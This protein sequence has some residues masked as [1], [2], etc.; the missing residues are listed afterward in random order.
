MKNKV[1]VIIPSFNE[2]KYIELC[3]RSVLQSEY[4]LLEIIVVDNGSSDRTVDIAR[5]FDI[6]LLI[7]PGVKVGAVRNAGVAEARGDIVI[8]LDADCLVSKNWISEGVAKLESGLDG[9]GGLYDLREN[10][11]WVEKAWVLENGSS[12]SQSAFVGGCIF[13]KKRVFEDVGGFN[14]RLSAG[15]DCDL[16]NRLRDKGY[17]IEIDSSLNVVHLGYPNTLSDFIKRQAWHSED[18]YQLFPGNV[19]DKVFLITHGFLFFL[20]GL[21]ISVFV[22]ELEAV[23]FF[24]V[25]VLVIPLVLSVKRILRFKPNKLSFLYFIEIYAIDFMYLIGRVIGAFRSIRK[26]FTQN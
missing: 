24:L 20:F 1:S 6:E 4:P 10:P 25:G 11:S 22:A 14:E 2:E 18:C 12:L 16:S 19:L 17:G 23:I 5:Q 3:I 15:E 8:F 21:C 9:V 26:L 13:I 7:K